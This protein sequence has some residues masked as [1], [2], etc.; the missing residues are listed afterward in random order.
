MATLTRATLGK[1]TQRITKDFEIGGNEVRIQKPTP[2]DK[3]R[4][5]MSMIDAEGLKDP[6]NIKPDMT[7]YYESVMRL[8]A[9]MWIDDTGKRVFEDHEWRLLNELEPEF[10][11]EL[12][13]ECQRFAEVA[14][15]KPGESEQTT[16]SDSL[17]ESA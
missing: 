12:S 1:L 4:Y 5:I 11:Q 16:A 13:G 8:T 2:L 9:A 17:V 14:A 3:S 10:Y 15:I 7:Q 6:K